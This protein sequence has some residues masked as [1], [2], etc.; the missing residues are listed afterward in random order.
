[1]KLQKRNNTYH[2]RKRMAARYLPVG[3]CASFYV[4]LNTDS[5]ALAEQ[6]AA[7]I[8]NEQVDVW[9]ARLAGDDVE[10]SRR[11][12]SLQAIAQTRGFPY[13]H[14]ADVADL[15]RRELLQRIEAIP[16]HES[17]PDKT[18]AAAVLGSVAAPVITVSR[19]LELY[20]NLVMD[21]TLGKS[22]D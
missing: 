16:V 2:L 9:E 5:L 4:S 20:W 3:D 6:K 7:A 22:E 12:A 8:W 10:A 1:M 14:A 15:P 11:H 17:T 13:L 19:A 21:K 18:I